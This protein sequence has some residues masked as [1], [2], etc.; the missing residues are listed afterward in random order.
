MSRKIGNRYNYTR[1]SSADAA[2]IAN[3]S[4]TVPG[5]KFTPASYRG[6]PLLSN[7]E[8]TK[9]LFLTTDGSLDT[10]EKLFNHANSKGFPI[11]TIVT[12]D[13]EQ[14]TFYWILTRPIGASNFWKVFLLQRGLSKFFSATKPVSDCMRAG[15]MT[16]VVG[17][18]N[19]ETNRIVGI[20]AYSGEELDNNK[21]E[22]ILTSLFGAGGVPTLER[23]AVLLQD[24]L[25]LFH[26][27]ILCQTFTDAPQIWLEAFGASMGMFC[28]EK[29]LV[30]ELKAVLC[31]LTNNKQSV[32][33]NNFCGDV[34]QIAKLSTSGDIPNT[35]EWCNEISEN[36]RVSGDEVNRLGLRILG[37]RHHGGYNL[38]VLDDSKLNAIGVEKFVPL[39][40]FFLKT[41]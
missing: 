29:D 28:D 31:T 19:P 17:S 25:A 11:P 16:S 3:M 27:R 9:C 8:S 36:L 18:V 12:S 37:F 22:S 33:K 30:K 2:K 23:S 5:I 35:E 4:Q 39:E 41:A 40:R 32:I 13:N 7:F 14:Q 10:R 38:K 21:A 24:L 20:P 34:Q 6:K 15:A 26:D 1:A